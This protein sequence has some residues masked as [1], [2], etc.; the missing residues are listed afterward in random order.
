MEWILFYLNPPESLESDILGNNLSVHKHFVHS[1]GKYQYFGLAQSTWAVKSTDYIA[2]EGSNSCNEWP[3]NDT[4][5][6]DRE[7][8][9]IQ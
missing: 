4:L 7:V 9:V 5:Q 2:A 3:V 6:S 8:P 1:M